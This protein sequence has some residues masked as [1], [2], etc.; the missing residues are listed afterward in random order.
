MA[1][2]LI[3]HAN[4]MV[5][6]DPRVLEQLKDKE[7]FDHEKLLEKNT[8]AKKVNLASNLE[9]ESILSGNTSTDDQKMKIKCIL[10]H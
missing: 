5:L 6:V 4:K 10:R 7:S 8:A 3:E 1:A 2:F 9:F